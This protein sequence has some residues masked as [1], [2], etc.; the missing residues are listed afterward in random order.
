MEFLKEINLLKRVSLDS[1][2]V[3]YFGA[4][5]A[6]DELWLV[7][8]YMEAS[9]CS[10]NPACHD[11]CKIVCFAP[12]ASDL[13]ILSPISDSVAFHDVP[14]LCLRLLHTQDN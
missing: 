8:E 10:P 3:Q 14:S 5:F 7:T 6:E 4:C 12:Y 1:N 11:L 2:I 9:S 13:L